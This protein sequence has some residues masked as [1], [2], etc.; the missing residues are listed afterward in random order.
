MRAYGMLGGR[1]SRSQ[2]VPLSP[3]GFLHVFKAWS[4]SLRGFSPCTATMLSHDQ[5]IYSWRRN[6]AHTQ[7]QALRCA[8]ALN[9]VQLLVGAEV[10]SYVSSLL[11]MQLNHA[12]ATL[13]GS[14]NR[15]CGRVSGVLIYREAPTTRFAGETAGN[16]GLCGAESLRS[17]MTS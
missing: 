15:V 3:L 5:Q 8:L 9:L 2:S 6:R 14:S 12:Y 7:R 4:R 16:A 13:E 11:S 17:L 10:V 1:R